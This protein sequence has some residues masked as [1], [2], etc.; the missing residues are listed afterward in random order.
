MPRVE[1]TV[2]VNAPKEKVVEVA[3]DFEKYPEYMSD[4]KSLKITEQS[5]D[6]SRVVAEWAALIPQFKLT[7]KWTQE[8][9]WD[10]AAQTD[11]FKQVKGD[12]D[13]MAG[14]WRFIELDGG[15]RI[16][17]IVDYEYTVPLLGPLVQKVIFNIVKQN[18]QKSLEAIKVRAEE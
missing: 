18:L 11:R 15:T 6:H 14:E 4:L 5:D 13:S 9:I 8:D 10:E 7:I 17:S 16:D 12:Y 1:N 2:L 3:R